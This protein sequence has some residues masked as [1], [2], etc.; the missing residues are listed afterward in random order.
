MFSS[1]QLKTHDD[2]SLSYFLEI[3]GNVLKPATRGQTN[4]WKLLDKYHD[5]N[6]DAILGK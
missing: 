6:F 4:S 3:T 5:I 2:F 1:D